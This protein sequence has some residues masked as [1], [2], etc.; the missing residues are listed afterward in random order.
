[1]PS[2]KAPHTFTQG[3]F[4]REREERGEGQGLADRAASGGHG[5]LQAVRLV[6]STRA[7]PPHPQAPPTEGGGSPAEG[8][9]L[10]RLEKS[11]LNLG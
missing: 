2:K 5:P 1:M 6:P 3:T 10:G 4:G 11:R 7:Q 8:R 9:A